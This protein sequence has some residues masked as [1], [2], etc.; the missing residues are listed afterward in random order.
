MIPI[1][2]KDPHGTE[3]PSQTHYVVASNGFFL[4]KKMFWVEAVVPVSTIKTLDKEEPSVKL[5]LPPLPVEILAKALKLAS[6]VYI[7]SQS[8]VGLLL[9]HGEVGYKLTVPQQ[10]VTR[11]SVR[12]DASVRLPG[13]LC[14]G[15]IHSHGSFHAFHSETD[16]DDERDA[17][18]VHITLGNID[19]YPK[20]SLSAEI[21]VNGVRFL[22]D[23]SWF[24]GIT[25][26]N[27]LYEIN[28]PSI[29]LQEIPEEWFGL[30]VHRK[31]L[32]Q[33]IKGEDKQ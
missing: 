22:L 6:V 23:R 14:V 32:H 16:L 24:E 21:V 17:D 9:H 1:H 12:Y 20:F 15:T 26:K 5:L 13:A 11:V 28:N 4:K 27:G 18:G 7:E 31:G 29:L 2:F 10:E 19:E 30:I 33:R 25:E 3:P 8:E